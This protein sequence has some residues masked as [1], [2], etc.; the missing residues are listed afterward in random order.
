MYFSHRWALRMTEGST[1]NAKRKV[2]L[3]GQAVRLPPPLSFQKQALSG[4]L[5]AQIAGSP[6]IP[7]GDSA[8]C[9]VHLVDANRATAQ[10]REGR[11]HVRSTLPEN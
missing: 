5:T 2:C 11:L 9:Q 8:G 10:A 7:G 3:V 6:D 1:K 4:S